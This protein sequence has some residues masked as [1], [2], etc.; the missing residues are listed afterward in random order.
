MEKQNEYDIIAKI[1]IKNE[2]N[3]EIIKIAIAPENSTMPSGS[4]KTEVIDKEIITKITGKM[5]IGRLNYTIDDIL[6][7]AILA[8]NVSESMD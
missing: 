5:S 6:K 1:T 4:I 2:K 7:A 3:P 8:N